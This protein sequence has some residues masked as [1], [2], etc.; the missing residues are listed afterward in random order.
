MPLLFAGGAFLVDSWNTRLRVIATLLGIQMLLVEARYVIPGFA[1]FPILFA[2]VAERY[3]LLG[4]TS[5][6]G[7]FDWRDR[8]RNE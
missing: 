3:R 6:D 1:Q 8:S 4:A 5:G 2:V 7:Q